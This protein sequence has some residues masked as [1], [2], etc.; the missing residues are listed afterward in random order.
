LVAA[1]ITPAIMNTMSVLAYANREAREQLDPTQLL[2]GAFN[3]SQ[4][5][6][7]TCIIGAVMIGLGSGIVVSC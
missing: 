6:M 2:G 3:M 4:H 1:L 5:L 7:L